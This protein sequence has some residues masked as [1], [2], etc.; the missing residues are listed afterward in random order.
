MLLIEQQDGMNTA[1]QKWWENISALG[2][3][4]P[5]TITMV[6]YLAVDYDVGV[7]CVLRA[8]Q[9]LVFYFLDT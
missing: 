6:V 2:E 9:A 4:L 5:L 7:R 8:L 1:T 3:A